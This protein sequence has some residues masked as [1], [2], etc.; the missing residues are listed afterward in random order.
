MPIHRGRDTKGPFYQWGEEKKYYYVAN[1]VKSRD[2]AYQRALT[3]ARAIEAS[4]A[5]AARH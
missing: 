1:D 3:Q 5:R 4:K 2:K